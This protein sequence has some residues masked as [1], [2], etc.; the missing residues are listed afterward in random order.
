[1]TQMTPP[2]IV[3]E[4]DKHIVGQA[5][6]KRAVAVALRNRW[7]RAQVTEPLR[8]EITP[9]NILMIGPT[10]VGKTEIARRMAQLVQAPF[11]KVEASRFTEVGYVGRDVETMIRDLVE[12]AMAEAR[13]RHLAIS[14]P[15]AR[16]LAQ[17]RL[18]D[19]LLPPPDGWK[20]RVDETFTAE[21]AE[22]PEALR[23][24]EAHQYRSTREKM[25]EKLRAGKLDDREI[26]IPV[27]EGQS[28][29]FMEIFSSSGVEQMG[30]DIQSMVDKIRG[31]QGQTKKPQIKRVKDAL[32]ILTQEE[33]E[34]L[35]D[36]EAI[37]AEAL[38]AAQQGGI[39]FIDEIDKVAG[40][41][42][43]GHGPDVSRE[44]VQRDLLPIVEGTTVQ[45]R[46]GLI[47][48]DHMLF[49]AA[50]AF[51]VSKPSDLIPEL[52][53]RFPIRVELEPLTRADLIRILTEPDNALTKQYTGLLGADGVRLRFEKDGVEAMATAAEQ[54]NRQ[55]QNI[56][57]RRLQTVMERILEDVAFLAP[58]SSLGEVVIGK[59]FVDERLKEA[60]S[61]EDL[62]KYIL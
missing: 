1:M 21:E 34:K 14:E 5:R 31:N 8:S 32:R 11:V 9:K 6:A 43:E 17:E 26:E 47:K 57:A 36:M 7:R 18:L 13:G 3:S 28:P 27:A 19:V 59:T 61:N 23:I 50:G 42:A 44:G 55:T 46:H 20:S 40:R 53:G 29:Q 56:G 49:I 2:E 48:T 54:I 39:V 15:K 30:F 45:T 60:L 35:V 22:S 12:V 25:R 52:Q 16:E 10:G 62:A 38:D 58:D 37:K 51:H 24:K 4:L 33:S 41:Q